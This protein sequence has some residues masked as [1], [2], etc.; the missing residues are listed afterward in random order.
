MFIQ[1]TISQDV[2]DAIIE[3]GEAIGR[4]LAWILS[5][6]PDDPINLTELLKVPESVDNAL[7]YVNWFL[8]IGTCCSIILTWFAALIIYQIIRFGLNAAQLM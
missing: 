3:V 4:F 5:F 2:C 7:A 8:P 6:L 1:A